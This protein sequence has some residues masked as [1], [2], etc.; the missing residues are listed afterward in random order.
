MSLSRLKRELI[1]VFED[2]IVS[3]GNNGRHVLQSGKV[4]SA[5]TDEKL[6]V[7]DRVLT[8][9]DNK[10]RLYILAGKK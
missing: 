9:E 10:K 5:L 1:Y 6:S 7:G 2:R 8:I 3:L 4:A